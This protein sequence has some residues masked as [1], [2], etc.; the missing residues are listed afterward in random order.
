MHNKNAAC[1]RYCYTSDII[2]LKAQ[3]LLELPMRYGLCSLYMQS[4]TH[5]EGFDIQ[6]VEKG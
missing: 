1:V 3:S 6:C 5:R 4:R 2:V